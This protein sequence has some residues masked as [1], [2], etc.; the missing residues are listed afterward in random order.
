MS[1]TLM[2]ILISPRTSSL[3]E[4]ELTKAFDFA[5]SLAQEAGVIMKRYFQASDIGIQ[6][7]EDDSPVT[8]ADHSINNLVIEKVKTH[9]PTH[10][11]IG[12]EGS[13]ESDRDWVWVVDP[14]DGTS[15]FS[16][17][18]PIS[19]FCLALV[20]KG[21]VQLS[22]VFDPFQDRLF[23]AQKGKG[24]FLNGVAIHVSNTK[25]FKGQYVMT[26]RSLAKPNHTGMNRMF[27]ALQEVGAKV[28]MFAS[29]SYAAMLVA[30]GRLVASCMVYGSPWDA[31]AA[32]LIVQEAGGLVTDMAGQPRDFS[33]WGEGLIMTNGAVH[34][35][36]ISLIDYEN[37]RD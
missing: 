7:K 36:I 13:Y 17:G 28:Y 2:L 23:T 9:Y 10:G 20:H 21:A 33:T 37:T 35:E 27:D 16:L 14:V 11:V 19:T 1:L 5:Q 25:T 31:A 29:F 12:E 3:T 24:A 18:I 32:S 30:E 15:P 26:F 8:V 4:V 22:V 34:S 6:L